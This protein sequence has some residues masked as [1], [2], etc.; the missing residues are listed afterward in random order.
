MIAAGTSNPHNTVASP[1][2]LFHCQA[3]AEAG[4]PVQRMIFLLLVIW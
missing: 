1:S 4:I 3:V 2:I